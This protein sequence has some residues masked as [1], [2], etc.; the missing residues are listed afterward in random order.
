MQCYYLEFA[1]STLLVGLAITALCHEAWSRQNTQ[2]YEQLTTNAVVRFAAK[3]LTGT[4]YLALTAGTAT[5]EFHPRLRHR[6]CFHLD[7][8]PRP[9]TISPPPP[10]RHWAP[11]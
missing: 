10:F 2:A 8:Y 11:Q 4:A 5:F 9:Q 6:G 3:A 1:L 7:W